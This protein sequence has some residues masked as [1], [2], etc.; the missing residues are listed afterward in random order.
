MKCGSCIAKNRRELYRLPFSKNDNPNGWLEITT[1][2]NLKCPKCYRGCDRDDIPQVHESFEDITFNI[3]ELIRIRNCQ[4]ISIS[5]GEPLLH[6][7]LHR[8]IAYI[9]SKGVKPWLHTNGVLLNKELVIS[10]KNDGLEGIIKW[11][12]YK[13][14]IRQARILI[15]GVLEEYRNQGIDLCLYAETFKNALRRKITRAE[16]AYVMEN[17]EKMRHI[18]KKLDAK[19]AKSYRL[20]ELYI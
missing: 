9:K 8:I 13:N 14:M 1:H 19:P 10:L 17:N 6:P 11:L 20:Y 15:L 18:M 12:Y 5:G 2:C 3:D 4:I 7:Q 16:A